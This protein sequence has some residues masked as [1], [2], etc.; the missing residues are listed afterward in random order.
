VIFFPTVRHRRCVV[1]PIGWNTEVAEP[2]VLVHAMPED[3][4]IDQYFVE[5]PSPGELW[6]ALRAD[7][8]DWDAREGG[9]KYVHVDELEKEEGQAPEGVF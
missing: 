3:I 9:A 6:K 7:G 5:P 2:Q 4:D 1:R 8:W